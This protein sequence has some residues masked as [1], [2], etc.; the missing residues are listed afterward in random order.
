MQGEL[1]AG[2]L[3]FLTLSAPLVEGKGS[4]REGWQAWPWGALGPRERK[5]RLGTGVRKGLGRAVAMYPRTWV[6]V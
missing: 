3:I 1:G 4:P 6:D 5:G 2:F